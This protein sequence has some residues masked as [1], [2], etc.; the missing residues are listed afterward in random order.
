MLS[1]SSSLALET[2]GNKTHKVVDRV[3][4]DVECDMLVRDLGMV[5]HN[6]EGVSRFAS[7]RV[8]TSRFE[9]LWLYI[10]KRCNITEYNRVI[11]SQDKLPFQQE[12]GS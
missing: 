11:E 6:L 8:A 1:F 7:D 2:K 12:A 10:P 5:D 4:P 9:Q 3:R